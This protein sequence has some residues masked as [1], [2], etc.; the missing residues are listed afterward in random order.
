[1]AIDLKPFEVVIEAEARKRFAE[2][3]RGALAELERGAPALTS[4][5]V[6]QDAG[7][8]TKD[9]EIGGASKKVPAGT[10]KKLRQAFYLRN[11][12]LRKEGQPT[13]SFAEFLLYRSGQK[14][15]VAS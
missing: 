2:L 6:P 7:L 4:P 8:K 3:L 9:S 10:D 5:V 15:S 12:K 11:W 13:L 14:K 1:M